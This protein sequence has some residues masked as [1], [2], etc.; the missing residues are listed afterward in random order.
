MIKAS[1]DAG[2]SVVRP[3]ITGSADGQGRI[4]VKDGSLELVRAVSG[5]QAMEAQANARLI[6]DDSASADTAFTFTGTNSAFELRDAADYKGSIAGFAAS[7]VLDLRQI[8]FSGQS[9]GYTPTGASSGTLTLTDGT[10]SAALK[11][12]GSYT[13]SSFNLASDTHG[14]TAITLA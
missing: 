13:A 7:D 9:A 12:L 1:G 2:R 8:A 14:G 5:H 10:H 3:A 6:L 4:V 11:L